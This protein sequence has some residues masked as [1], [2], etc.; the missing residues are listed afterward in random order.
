MLYV[1]L[2]YCSEKT[3]LPPDLILNRTLHVSQ[4]VM[5]A[6]LSNAS[7]SSSMFP[8]GH[9]IYRQFDARLCRSGHSTQQYDTDDR[10][11]NLYERA[12][13]AAAARAVSIRRSGAE[14]NRGSKFLLRVHEVRFYLYASVETEQMVAGIIGFQVQS[15]SRN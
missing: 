7:R 5:H 1:I 14:N 15:V 13:H 8:P 9:H 12:R 10:A 2:K 11:A 4:H 6:Q 3:N